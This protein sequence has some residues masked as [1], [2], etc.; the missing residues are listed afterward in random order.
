MKQLLNVPKVELKDIA[1]GGSR[2]PRFGRGCLPR[3]APALTCEYNLVLNPVSAISGED[4]GYE[5][6][7]LC[8]HCSAE[9]GEGNE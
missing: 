3:G 8:G 6:C 1:F 9:G 2:V 5:L 7:F 4:S